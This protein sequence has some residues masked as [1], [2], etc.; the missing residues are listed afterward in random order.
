MRLDTETI[1]KHVDISFDKVGRCRLTPG[2][3]QLTPRL[4]SGTF[5]GFQLLKLKY[6]ELLSNFA[7][8]CN[9]CRYNKV[10]VHKMESLVLKELGGAVQVDPGLEAVDPTL[11]F[12][13]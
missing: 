11:A 4:L 13:S 5:R 7:F 6:E 2:W 12:S 8:N 3:K 9:L 1:Q 10:C